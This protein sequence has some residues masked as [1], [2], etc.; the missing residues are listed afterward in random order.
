MSV[1]LSSAVT[2]ARYVAAVPRLSVFYGI[3]I[4]L[5]FEDHPPPYIHARY[6]EHESK[7]LIATGETI[8]GLLPRRATNLVQEWAALHRTELEECWSRSIQ[9]ESPG[10]IEPLP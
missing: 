2:A 9:G 7:V 6:G 1:A 10:T 8:E 4:Y 3:A 5:Y